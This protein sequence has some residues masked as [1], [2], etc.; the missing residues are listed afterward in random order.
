MVLPGHFLHPSSVQPVPNIWPRILA[1]KSS[2]QGC[3]CPSLYRPDLVE[4]PPN[5]PSPLIPRSSQPL[6]PPFALIQIRFPRAPLS[7]HLSSR[8]SGQDKLTLYYASHTALSLRSHPISWRH[9]VFPLRLFSA[10]RPHPKPSLPILHQP[11]RPAGYPLPSRSP[12]FSPGRP[13][14]QSQFIPPALA[15]PPALTSQW[16]PLSNWPRGA[17]RHWAPGAAASQLS[18]R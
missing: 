2:I 15:V 6:P 13:L 10:R 4:S 18:E 1:L 16:P 7:I 8:L 9:P 5:Y 11:S 14:P 17:P 12:S 3:L